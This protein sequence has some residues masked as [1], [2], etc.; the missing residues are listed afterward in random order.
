MNCW[1]IQHGRGSLLCRLQS[2]FPILITTNLGAKLPSRPPSYGHGTSGPPPSY[3]GCRIT[4]VGGPATLS[5]ASCRWGSTLNKFNSVI[6]GFS[7]RRAKAG[8]EP[9]LSRTVVK[10]SID[11]SNAASQDFLKPLV[12]FK[13]S[14]T[15]WYKNFE[16]CFPA[17]VNDSR[18]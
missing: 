12:P 9:L 7:L 10:C 8:F 5:E 18:P 3:S 15:S 16:W 1:S 4:W 14:F 2:V 17:D 6:G 13:I 11:C